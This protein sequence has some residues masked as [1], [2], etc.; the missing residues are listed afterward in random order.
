MASISGGTLRKSRQ[1]TRRAMQMGEHL[2]A[3]VAEIVE[4]TL[5]SDHLEE[6]KARRVEIRTRV[7]RVARS[8]LR[9]HV[10]RRADGEPLRRDLW[11]PSER[12]TC[13]TPKSRT[14]TAP[15]RVR[16]T[17]AGLISR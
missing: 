6:Q 14:L 9:G 11:S 1:G 17:L 8:L 2:L 15:S 7:G 10:A 3:R 12:V 13:A 16:N 5:A 4:G